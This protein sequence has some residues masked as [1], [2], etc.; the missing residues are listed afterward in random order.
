TKPTWLTALSQLGEVFAAKRAGD[1]LSAFSWKHSKGIS[2]ARTPGMSL[3][4]PDSQES[5]ARIP[6]LSPKPLGCVS[7][8]ENS[9]R[10]QNGEEDVNDERISVVEVL[11]FSQHRLSDPNQW[12]SA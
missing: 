3:Q 7:A 5:L 4:S 8:D 9:C 11:E 10:F 1:V 6:G 12:E 2:T